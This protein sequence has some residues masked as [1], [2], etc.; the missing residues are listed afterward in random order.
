MRKRKW[1]DLSFFLT[2][3]IILLCSALAQEN[4]LQH[5]CIDR[6][7][8]YN[9]GSMY[10]TNLNNLLSTL[11]SQIDQFGYTNSTSGQVPDQANAVVLCRGDVDPDTCRNC[12]TS[13]IPILTGLCPRNNEAVG[14]WDSC[15][16]RYSN[17]TLTGPESIAENETFWNYN[18]KT[19]ATNPVQFKEVAQSLL[20]DLKTKAETGGSRLKFAAGNHIGP[21]F[22]TIY[23]IVQ[24]T[25]DL[26]EVSCSDC[27]TRTIS[28][29]PNCC[30][31]RIGG[32][33]L[34][35]NCNFRYEIDAFYNKSNV[36]AL[37][38]PPPPGPGPVFTLKRRR[39]MRR[40]LMHK[41]LNPDEEEVDME[42]MS[43]EEILKY[44]FDD[45]K[46][47]TNDFSE[48]NKLGKGGFGSVYMG[49]FPNGQNFAVKRLSSKSVQGEAEFKNEV[50]LVAKLQHRNLVRILG[51]SIQGTERLLVYELLTNSSLDKFLS[52]P[53]KREQLDWETRFKI[54]VGIARGVLYLHEDSRHRI[55]HRDLKAANI[56][57]DDEMNPKIADFG[58]AKLSLMD[59]THGD[60][61][62]IAGTYGYMA[63]EYANYGK[64]SVKSDVFSFGVILLEIISGQKNR[65]FRIG[66]V[67]E[68]MLSYASRSWKEE[69]CLNLI[70]PAIRNTGG[71]MPN[72]MRC[73]HIA[74]L[75]TQ[76]NASDRPTMASI[77]VMLTG[78]SI[79]LP[80]P[81]EPGLFN[82]RIPN[83]NRS[84][85]DIDQSSKS[86]GLN[87][88][89]N[90]VTISELNPR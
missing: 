90:T 47:A 88:S 20:E 68:D 50:M 59:E 12:A 78:F 8:F 64:F 55:I 35:P 33:V 69:D 7:G 31:S 23:A 45:I 21:D 5:F 60:T 17:Q 86:N 56:L 4:L 74:L 58:M 85:S 25:P 51:Y 3:F 16:L 80:L 65:S 73:I 10:Q 67:E 34:T 53:V 22:Q 19:N 77:V 36:E 81:F 66:D 9:D 75:C 2:C 13:S 43:N 48:S 14:W 24:C 28:L 32:R 71:S 1:V 6:T 84:N 49:K 38:P 57:L 87:N 29:Y 27:L 37:T 30:D 70:D 61:R 83:E 15:M 42:D 63:P 40:N 89:N 18:D 44:E 11:P 54:I 62:R 52:D 82:Q 39:S 76:D 72:I 46:S 79:T 26:S 41:P